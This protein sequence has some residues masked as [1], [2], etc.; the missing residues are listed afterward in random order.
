[1]GRC[2]GVC[3]RWRVS[4]A[5]RA[6]SPRYLGAR[7]AVID[8]DQRLAAGASVT[9]LRFNPA[10]VGVPTRLGNLWRQRSRRSR[11]A[12]P[13]TT[14]RRYLEVMARWRGEMPADSSGVK[15]QATPIR[16]LAVPSAILTGAIG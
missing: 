12:W 5:V 1:M 9:G 4:M 8:G 7:R 15:P 6:A 2:V 3:L 16:A 14:Y 10:R 13:A 11:G